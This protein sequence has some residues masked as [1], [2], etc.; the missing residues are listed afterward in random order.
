MIEFIT[1]HYDEVLQIIGLI[2][3]IASIIVKFTPSTKD[4]TIL[5]K[6]IMILSKFSIFNNKIDQKIIDEASKNYGTMV[7]NS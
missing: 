5:N 2:V 1:N 7:K 6:V 3:S 4:D